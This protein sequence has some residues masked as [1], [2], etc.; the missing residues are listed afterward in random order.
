LAQVVPAATERHHFV[1]TPASPS[2][3]RHNAR[4]LTGLLNFSV[5][6]RYSF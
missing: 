2:N 4:E 5:G 3:A 1:R 6:F